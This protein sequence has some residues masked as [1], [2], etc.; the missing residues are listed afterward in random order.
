MKNKHKNKKKP[1]AELTRQEQF[2]RQHRRHH[3][4]ISTWRTII[5]VLF[6]ILWEIS[7]DRKWIDSFF[8]SSPSRVIR[9]F[10][11]QLKSNSLLSHIG[12]TLFETLFSFLLVLLLKNTS[13]F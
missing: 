2:V 4:E 8:F 1:S 7:A 12:V 11:E 5:F 13:Y 9:C 6:L 3:H 10:V